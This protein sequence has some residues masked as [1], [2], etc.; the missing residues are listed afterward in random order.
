MS[1]AAVVLLGVIAAATLV[2]AA[3]QIAL[4]VAGLRLARQVRDLGERVERD[5]RPL[6]SHATAVAENAARVSELALVQVERADR[7]FND[8]ALRIDETSRLV[9][10]VVTA[11]AREGRAWLAAVGAAIGAVRSAQ[12]ERAAARPLEDDD[13]LFIG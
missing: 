9:R 3:I 1:T 2:T 10:G 11:P 7:V 6:V 4:A 12:R 8:L 5:I 13:P